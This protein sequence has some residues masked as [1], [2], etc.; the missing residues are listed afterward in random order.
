MP[1][2]KKKPTKKVSADKKAASSFSMC[3]FY[4]ACRKIFITLI[5]ILLVYVIVFVATLI[6]NNIREYESIGHAD[7]A[8]R[9]ILIEA[10]GSV[11]AAP[12]VAITNMGVVSEGTTVAEAQG[13]STEVMNALQTK[14][15][16][17]G[18]AKSDIQ[19]TQ[20][21]IFPLYNYTEEEGRLLNGY[22]VNQEVEIKIRNLSK[23]QQVL[24]L[25]GEVG[26]NNVSGLSFTV[27]NREVYKD[28]ARD[29][30]L[31]QIATKAR[32]ISQ[33]LGVNM[34]GISSYNEYELGAGGIESVRSLDAFG[35]GAPAIEPGSMDVEMNVT[36][37]FEIR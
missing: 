3:Y 16:Q 10:Q 6:R 4:D 11:T 29:K 35:G 23:A 1:V 31:E 36:V 19:T 7:K 28:E 12:D 22:Q 17:M 34:V 37:V 24:A 15:A 25:A 9:T 21:N 8:E 2:K 18:V 13:R 26:A 14:L 32:S 27:D 5:G 20:Y 30:A 33:S